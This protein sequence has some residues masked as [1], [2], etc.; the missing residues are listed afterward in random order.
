M[1]VSIRYGITRK[2]K[3]MTAAVVSPAIKK[4]GT[5]NMSAKTIERAFFWHFDAKVSIKQAAEFACVNY[6]AL[7]QAAWRDEYERCAQ[8]APRTPEEIPCAEQKLS[9]A[10]VET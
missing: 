2:R 9:R 10:S 1:L 3:R 7:R 8:M 6:G 4:K 5:A